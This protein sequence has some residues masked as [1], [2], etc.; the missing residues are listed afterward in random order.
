MKSSGFHIED[1][2]LTEQDRIEKL[3][4]VVMIAFVWAYRVGVFINENIK[5]VRI[6]N[7][8]RRA[9]SLFKY[10]LEYIATCL[11]K[12]HAGDDLNIFEF[13]SCT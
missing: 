7:N 5:P 11:L 3:F 12:Q 2:H 6:L 8:G 13:L 4:T 9:K 1:T 10:G